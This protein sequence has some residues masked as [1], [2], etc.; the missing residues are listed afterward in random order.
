MQ[1]ESA[2][3]HGGRIEVVTT[4][5]RFQIDA[6][7]NI[8][9]WQRI[10]H[11]RRVLAVSFRPAAGPFHIAKKDGF[12]CTV[13]CRRGTLTFQ[14]DGLIILR[15]AANTGV[16]FQGRF[17]P[18][19][20]F[21]KEGKWLLMDAEGGFGIYPTVKK[22][23][24]APLLSQPA[25]E[26]A[27]E[28]AAGEETWV[29][30]FPPRP[31]NWQRAHEAIEHDG[32]PAEY[33]PTQLEGAGAYPGN[34]LIAAAAK[35]CKIYTLHA[36]IW[37][38]A[39]ED[40][41]ARMIPIKHT[42]SYAGHPQPW[43]A[44]QFIPLDLAEFNRVRDEV[45][46]HGMRLV[47]YVSPFYSAAPDILAEEKRILDTYQVDGLYFDGIS[48]DFRRS[49]E[50]MRQTRALLGNDRILYVHCSSDPLGDGRIYC[51]FIDTYADYTLRGEAGVW[52]LQRDDFLRWTVSGDNISNAV[53]VWC[54]YGSNQ[55]QGFGAGAPK[56]GHYVDTPPTADA[57]EAAIRNHV[58]IWREGQQWSQPATKAALDQF[59]HYYYP[60]VELLAAPR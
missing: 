35:Y 15:T 52:G 17:R 40:V 44:P 8:E 30:V 19:Y 11:E 51:P 6:S 9:C 43:L 20:H 49:Y 14:A 56:S 55:Q 31:F 25:W 22:S 3:D 28:F 34:D 27:Y 47:V 50:V 5:A 39:P 42:E 1:I 24:S 29:S 46:R 36:Y 7:G 2:S 59:D 10:P 54:Y 60:K 21:E 13:A 58:F 26:I 38:D 53:G 12:A 32:L 23:A 37:R 4:G 48:M 33:S 45:H 18:A 16:R 41:K 57:V